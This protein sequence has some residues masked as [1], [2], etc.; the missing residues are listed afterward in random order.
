MLTVVENYRAMLVSRVRSL[1]E[2]LLIACL[3]P[4]SVCSLRDIQEWLLVWKCYFTNL[5]SFNTAEKDEKILEWVRSRVGPRLEASDFG[6]SWRSGILLCA[7]VE[8]IA[9]GSCPRYDLLNEENRL[10]NA[11]LAVQLIEKINLRPCLTAQELS[12][13]DADIEK[14]LKALLAQFRMSAAKKKLRNA[15][16]PR[17]DRAGSGP[18][19]ELFA[20]GMGLI[21]AVKGRKASFNIFRRGQGAFSFVIEIQGPDGTLGSA[22]ITHKSVARHPGS[23]ITVIPSSSSGPGLK[24]QLSA[25]SKTIVIDYTISD[26]KISV[27]YTPVTSG[28]HTLN[29]VAQGQHIL[30]SPYDISVDCNTTEVTAKV[31]ETLFRPKISALQRLGR[32]FSG[33]SLM[34]SRAQENNIGVPFPH[35]EAT[36]K[37]VARRVIKRTILGTNIVINGDSEQELVLALKDI[38]NLNPKN[39]ERLQQRRHTSAST[40][41]LRPVG[42]LRNPHTNKLRYGLDQSSS[43]TSERSSMDDRSPAVA[44]PSS[45][46]MSQPLT[47]DKPQ[48]AAPDRVLQS[49]RLINDGDNANNDRQITV[50]RSSGKSLFSGSPTVGAQVEARTATQ[51]FLDASKAN[52][53]RRW[54]RGGSAESVGDIDQYNDDDENNNPKVNIVH[55]HEFLIRKRDV[56]LNIINENLYVPKIS[57]KSNNA[58]SIVNTTTSVEKADSYTLPCTD[59]SDENNTNSLR[60]SD[61]NALERRLLYQMES[62]NLRLK[63]EWRFTPEMIPEKESVPV[64]PDEES[65]LDLDT[66]D[67]D[68]QR[69]NTVLHDQE[70]KIEHR[71]RQHRTDSS[72][73]HLGSEVDEV[74]DRM[75]EID[76]EF[77]QISV[78]SV[79]DK[80]TRFSPVA[81]P[82]CS[83]S[84]FSHPSVIS[85]SSQ[86]SPVS[87]HSGTSSLTSYSGTP[88]ELEDAFFIDED[89]KDQELLQETFPALFHLRS[90]TISSLNS[91]INCQRTTSECLELIQHEDSTGCREFSRPELAPSKKDESSTSDELFNVPNQLTTCTE[92]FDI[93][94]V[95]GK[96]PPWSPTVTPR[97]SSMPRGSARTIS[98]YSLANHGVNSYD[99]LPLTAPSGGCGSQFSEG[100]DEVRVSPHRCIATGNALYCGRT[101]R[102]LVFEVR[103]LHAGEGFLSVTVQGPRR[104]AVLETSVILAKRGLFRVHFKVQLEGYYIIVVKWADWQVPGSPF[105]CKITDQ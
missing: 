92:P 34:S 21:F 57:E 42:E 65:L 102:A 28:K 90:S 22:L 25:E 20:K 23:P 63:S 32:R 99:A 43:K 8:S 17:D 29:I 69:R 19:A 35:A 39:R 5:I 74:E 101:R 56:T 13:D 86:H 104:E 46:F 9:P 105:L 14:P 88:S 98:G 47:G 45:M 58:E 76:G 87:S 94:T 38:S 64:T 48:V 78:S 70:Q 53:D 4:A 3:H 49:S 66:V 72:E 44:Q 31:V 12:S 82:D 60:G 54:Q 59:S 68:V 51:N 62:K 27:S 30:R 26:E 11:Q 1:L 79:L 77:K 2:W 100:D 6:P 95:S 52:T 80:F 67:S 16:S 97:P 96:I 10:A 41:I 15:L 37:V 75:Q 33:T 85:P 55:D 84:G 36:G 40:F 89:I 93:R 7:L 71:K 24:R 18:S 50:K 83:T 103:T 91:S 73:V 61:Q 81:S